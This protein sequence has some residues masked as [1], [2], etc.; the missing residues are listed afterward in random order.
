MVDEFVQ[1]LEDMRVAFE[2]L[3]KEFVTTIDI[4]VE[5]I[6]RILVEDAKRE[7]QGKTSYGRG[8]R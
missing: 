7:L 5:E 1:D 3:D 6:K 4:D 8:V 2:N